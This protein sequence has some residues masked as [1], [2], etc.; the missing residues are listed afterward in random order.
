MVS[1]GERPSRRES[2]RAFD[3]VTP[4]YWYLRPEER[5]RFRLSTPRLAP[6]RNRRRWNLATDDSGWGLMA[7]G[8]GLELSLR[9][10]R[11]RPVDTVIAMLS[12]TV[13]ACA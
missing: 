4:D 10:G 2:E 7:D 6:A 1:A 12:P 13:M 9:A 3:H 11:V 5:R 8:P